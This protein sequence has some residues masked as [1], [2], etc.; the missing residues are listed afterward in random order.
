MST[1]KT[2]NLPAEHLRTRCSTGKIEHPTVTAAQAHANSI[3]HKDGHLPNVYICVEC[4]LF[5]IGGGRASDR[6]AYRP[7]PIVTTSRPIFVRKKIDKGRSVYPPAIILERLRTSYDSSEKIATDLGFSYDKVEK[8]R[9]KNK[10]GTRG[11]RMRNDVRALLA[12][13]PTRSRTE[14]ATKLGISHMTVARA[15]RDLGLSYTG[16]ARRLLRGPRHPMF[17]RRH[18]ARARAKMSANSPR[19]RPWMAGEKSPHYGKPSKMK[20]KTHTNEARQK[21]SRERTGRPLSASHRE[22][23]AAGR[24]RALEEQFLKTVAWG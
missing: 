16:T 3:F 8:V 18:T 7:V 15:V 20:G 11:E 10:V 13:D 2:G 4:G 6:P 24:K 14:I 19:I 21:M 9:L 12:A 22:S 1:S 23:I 17:G 5:H